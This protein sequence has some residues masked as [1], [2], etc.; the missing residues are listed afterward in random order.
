MNPLEDERWTRMAWARLS[1]P[2]DRVAR[3][4]IDQLGLR[5]ALDLVLHGS[6]RSSSPKAERFAARLADFDLERDL[7]VTQRCGARVI[8]PG[9]DEWPHGLADLDAPPMCLWVRG[10]RPLGPTC[11]RSVSI[12]G[13]RAATAYGEYVAA[14]LA[15]RLAARGFTIVSGAAFGIDAAA[16]RG[17]LAN[18]AP[19]V[20]VMAG[21]VERAYPAAHASLIRQIA[22]TSAVVSEV[23]PGSAPTRTR[24]LLRNRLIATLSTGT[25]VIEA[26]LRSGA[27][28]T[29]GTAG[30][31]GRPVGAV[32]GPVTSMVSAGCHQAV[33]EGL[34]VLVTDAEEAAELIGR[35]GADLAPVKRGPS[36]AADDLDELPLRVLAVLPPYRSMSVDDLARSGGLGVAE[37][38]AGLGQLEVAGLVEHRLDG[39]SQVRT[40]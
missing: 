11:A 12:V 20:A 8:I 24:F 25:I 35:I 33:R 18:D 39:W 31:K 1:E 4:L 37:V 3:S 32:P 40:G 16:H 23:P 36:R 29:A 30:K 17:A 34:A 21:G 9:D 28:N 5:D 22:E 7:E 2:A 15:G 26:G 6:R 27:L 14:D 38:M 13:A 19:T 10:P